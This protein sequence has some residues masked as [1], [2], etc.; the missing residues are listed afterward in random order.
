MSEK[1]IFGTNKMFSE[2][3]KIW[4][5]QTKSCLIGSKHFLIQRNKKTSFL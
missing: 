5:I 1:Y 4:L 2:C 3:N